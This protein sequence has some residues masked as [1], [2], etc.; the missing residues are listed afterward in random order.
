R[1]KH[2]QLAFATLLTVGESATAAAQYYELANQLANVVQ[3]ALSGSFKY[4]G[5][6]GASYVKN[7]GDFNADYIELST[8]QGFQYATWFYM[9]A[10]LGFDLLNSHPNDDWGNGWDT[11][12]PGSYHRSVTTAVMMPLFT[13]FRFNIGS[14]QA[15][16]FFIDLRIGCSFLLTDSWVKINNGYLTDSEYF[17]L[18][19]TIGVRIP[20]NPNNSKQALNLGISYQL[21]TSNYWRSYESNGSLSGL[22]VGVSYEW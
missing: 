16:N 15:T 3:P 12:T 10:G 5:Y 21:L 22:G 4:K 9:G 7:L 20:V 11:P 17:Y 19:P 2:Y 8:S 14:P 1:K 18:K 6:A 13:D